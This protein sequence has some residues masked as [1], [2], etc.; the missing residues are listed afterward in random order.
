[1]DNFGRL[2]E[3]PTHPELL[4]YLATK[5]SDQHNWSIKSLIREIVTSQTWQQTSIAPSEAKSKDP[6]NR[7]LSHFPVMRLEAE[8]I[9]DK[10]LAVS[11][12]LEKNLYGPPV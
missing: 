7:Y 12:Q 11:G 5:F 8:A 4:D 1:M 2:G 10:L 3:E 9:R 6:D